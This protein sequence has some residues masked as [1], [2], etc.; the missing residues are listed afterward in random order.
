MNKKILHS[1][2]LV[3]L[4]LPIAVFGQTI[5]SMAAAI[6]TQVVAVGTWIV[7][8]MWVV[9]GVMFLMA[10]GDPGKLGAAKTGLFAAI[11]GTILI[12]LATGAIGFIERSF[13]IQMK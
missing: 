1:I 9:A 5:D 11:G 12:I 13:G 4:L 3:A 10:A 6:A 8:I 2:L 7:V